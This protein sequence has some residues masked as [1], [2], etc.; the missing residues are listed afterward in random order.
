VANRVAGVSGAGSITVSVEHPSGEF[1][2]Q[3]GLN[4]AVPGGVEKSGLLR[5]ARLIMAGDVLVPAHLWSTPATH[6][7]EH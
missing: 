4:P 2:V 5:T 7:Q 6:P 3:L 1:T